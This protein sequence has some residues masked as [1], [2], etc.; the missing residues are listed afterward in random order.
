M[1]NVIITPH[2]GAQ[3]STRVDDSTNLFCENLRRYLRGERLRNIVDKELGFPRPS[4][5]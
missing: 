1:P 3:S 5:D 4:F 2:V